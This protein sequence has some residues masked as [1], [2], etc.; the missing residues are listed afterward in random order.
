M[1]W[2]ARA[3]HAVYQSG[4]L[5]GVERF[6]GHQPAVE[7]HTGKGKRGEVGLDRWWQVSGGDASGDRVSEGLTPHGRVAMEER[8][9]AVVVFG[10][11]DQ[12]RDA[13]RERRVGEGL[14]KVAQ[15]EFDAFA[16]GGSAQLR[17]RL[18]IERLQRVSDQ[19]ELVAP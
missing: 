14:G 19:G 2:L 17:S 4:D 6:G 1:C 10:G 3:K 11:F 13:G 18:F 16:G 5:R 15:Q 7:E 8:A 9:N 12:R